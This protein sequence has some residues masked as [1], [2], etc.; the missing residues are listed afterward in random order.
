ME[1]TEKIVEAYVRY[2]KGWATIPNVQCLGKHE[3]DLLAI[4]PRT[5]EKYHIEV[6][7]SISGSFSKLTAHPFD[8]EKYKD[9]RQKPSQRRTLDYFIER[10]FNSEKVTKTLENLG[11]KKGQYKKVIVSWG[12]KE[13][14]K[15]LAI[16]FLY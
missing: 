14:V 3:V 11:F 12:W 4:N 2:L 10:K 5:N 13:D 9:T 15:R 8:P 1:T 6:S 7:I 16:T